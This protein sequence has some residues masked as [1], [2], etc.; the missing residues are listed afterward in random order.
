MKKPYSFILILALLLPFEAICQR[1]VEVSIKPIQ[2]AFLN[3]ETHIGIGTTKTRYGLFVSFRPSTQDSGLVKSGGVGMA[4]GY[5]HRYANWLYAS[6]TIGLYNKVYFNKTLTTFFES[7]IFFR[8]WHFDKK[9]A[10]FHD[11][12]KRLFEFKGIR[13]ENV[14][15]YGIKLLA[16][17]TLFFKANKKKQTKPFVDIYGGIGIR[18]QEETFETFNGYVAD[19]FY[20]YKIDKFYH[21]WLTP[22]F[23]LKIGL[24]KMK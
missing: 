23:E 15:V 16:G 9:P 21:V 6:Y 4:G 10:E 12:E 22:Q 3:F 1:V 19:T 8:N 18:Y 11:V 7:D 13:T 5:G 17:R 2:F 14:D 24:I 20:T